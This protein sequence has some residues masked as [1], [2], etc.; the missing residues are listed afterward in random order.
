MCQ[1]HSQVCF[2]GVHWL[3]CQPWKTFLQPLC[4]HKLVQKFKEKNYTFDPWVGLSFLLQK[5]VLSWK[6]LSKLFFY[7]YSNLLPPDLFC[8]FSVS[9]RKPGKYKFWYLL[10]TNKN[11]Y[12]SIHIH[13]I[14]YLFFCSARICCNPSL[15]GQSCFFTSNAV[16]CLKK[17]YTRFKIDYNENLLDPVCII[18][19]KNC[20][21]WQRFSILGAKEDDVYSLTRLRFNFGRQVRVDTILR[22]H[23]C[24]IQKLDL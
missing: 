14:F 1:N 12:I 4:K 17:L 18:E 8:T 2:G 23:Q 9:V 16:Q 15:Y 21:W 24:S 22:K 10:K 7:F 11:G 20:R 3:P 6:I 19:R 13:F 5:T